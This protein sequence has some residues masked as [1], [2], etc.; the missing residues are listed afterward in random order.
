VTDVASDAAGLDEQ[1]VRQLTERARAE[2]LRLTGEGGLLARLTK[3]VVESS[4]EGITHTSWVVC[5]RHLG[6]IALWTA[7][8]SS[9]AGRYSYIL[10]AQAHVP[11]PEDRE[12]VPVR[13]QPQGHVLLRDCGRVQ[14]APAA[15]GDLV[16]P[17]RC[18]GAGHH[19]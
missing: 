7:F 3:V 10:I 12:T 15:G 14:L 8:P 17:A 16:A 5:V 13:P 9:L 18:P 1:L 6:P 2:G 11:C 4:L 19:S